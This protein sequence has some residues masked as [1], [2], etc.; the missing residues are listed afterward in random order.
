LREIVFLQERRILHK[1]DFVK[2][3]SQHDK[4]LAVFKWNVF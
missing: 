3:N 2:V 4:V 1:N